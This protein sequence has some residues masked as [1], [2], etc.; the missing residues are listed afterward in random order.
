M[1]QIYQLA[2]ARLNA[3][4]KKMAVAKAKRPTKKAKAARQA[5]EVRVAARA[6]L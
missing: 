1:A 3:E 4:L 2:N 6:V 5:Y